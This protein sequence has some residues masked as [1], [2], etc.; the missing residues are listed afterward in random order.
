MK[1]KTV[2]ELDK[3]ANK[4]P[5]DNFNHKLANLVST[6]SPEKWSYEGKA[7][8]RILSNYIFYTFEKLH[9][10]YN[11]ADETRKNTIIFEGEDKACFNTGLYNNNWQPV[12]FYCTKNRIEGHQPWH[13]H[14][15]QTEY[16]LAHL[17]INVAEIRRANYFAEP[18]DLV[19]DFSCPIVPQWEHILGEDENYK[20]IPEAVRLLGKDACQTLIAG[21][22]DKTKK[23]IEANYKTVVPQWYKGRIQL[24]IPLYLTSGERPDLALVMSKNEATKQYFG[25]TCLTCEMA[26]NNAR[27]IARPESYWLDPM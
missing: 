26:Y 18:S 25:H 7:D 20:R 13:F 27:L 19:Y 1:P 23:R 8:Y 14:S 15:F 17:G 11:E 22:I 21:S 4:G 3:W 12:F 6:L 5:Y 24:L 10:E 16:T 9:S 2:F